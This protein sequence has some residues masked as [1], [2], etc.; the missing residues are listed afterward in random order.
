MQSHAGDASYREAALSRRASEQADCG[1]P[2]LSARSETSIAIEACRV[3]RA[4]SAAGAET[5]GVAR[6]DA[7]RLPPPLEIA[8][9]LEG[10]F[11]AIAAARPAPSTSSSTSS[12]AS[13]DSTAAAALPKPIG[14][15]WLLERAAQHISLT[16][17]LGSETPLSVAQRIRSALQGDEVAVQ[18]SLFELLGAESFE[19]MSLLMQNVVKLKSVTSSQL[20]RAVANEQRAAAKAEAKQRQRQGENS[21]GLGGHRVERGRS[22]KVRPE[23]AQLDAAVG[24]MGMYGLTADMDV[25]IRRGLPPG[26]TI[27]HGDRWEEVKV[28]PKRRPEGEVIHRVAIADLEE[29]AQLA[30]PGT[31]HLNRLQSAIF[32]QAHHS[33]ENLLVCAPTGAGKTNVAMLTVLNLVRRFIVDGVLQRDKFK[34]VYV[35]PMKALAQEVVAKFGKRLAPLGMKVNELTG[36]MQ[37][38][39]KQLEQT[40]M[41]VTTPEKW[42]VITRKSESTVGKLV[43]L[44]IFDEIHL[45][46]DGRGPVIEVLVARTL[47]RVEASQSMV[48]I[49]GLSA[50]LP[51]YKDVGEFL[52][53]NP[54]TG[55]FYADDS[56]R[57]VPLS[58]SFI[59]VQEKHHWKQQ[60]LFDEIAF[61][62][63]LRSVRQGN[64]CMIFVH[65]RN[66]TVKTAKAM[67]EAATAEGLQELFLPQAGDRA[68]QQLLSKAMKAGGVLSE[69]LPAGFGCHHAGML[70][71]DRG[72][73][74]KLFAAGALKCIVCTATLAWGVNLPAHTVIIKGTTVYNAD[75]G[76]FVQISMLDVMQIFGRA[77]RPQFDTEGEAIMITAQEHATKFVRLLTRQMPIES[78]FASALEDH[79]NAEVVAGTVASVDEA[80][81]W[82]TYTYLYTRMRRNPMCYGISWDTIRADPMLVVARRELIESAARKL[83]DCRMLR[84][85]ARSGLLA[86]TDLGR[87]ASHYYVCHETIAVW[88]KMLRAHLSDSEL[89]HVVC[90]AQEFEQLK[91]RDEE[92]AELMIL[93]RDYCPVT[94]FR[95]AA[96]SQGRYGTEDGMTAEEIRSIGAG[97]GGAIALGTRVRG[98]GKAQGR[99]HGDGGVGALASGLKGMSGSA[100]QVIA[101]LDKASA[102]DALSKANVMLQSYISGARPST[103]T[104]I[105]DSYYVG[106]N[107]ARISRALFEILMY[108][109]WGSTALA[110][111][112]LCKAIDHQLWWATSDAVSRHGGRKGKSRV[113][114]HPLRQFSQLRN[115][116]SVLEN[117]EQKRVTI[118]RLR[119]MDAHEVGALVHHVRAGNTVL[120]AANNFP[121]L[122]LSATLHPITRGILRMKVSV[123]PDFIW[124]K[125]VHGDRLSYWVW[126]EDSDSERIYHSERLNIRRG[127]DDGGAQD[128]EFVIPVEE[129]LPSQFHIYAANDRWVSATTIATVSLRHLMLPKAGTALTPLLDL[130][131]LAVASVLPPAF[132]PLFAVKFSHFNPIQTQMFHTAYHSDQSMLLGAPTGS[133]KTA[134]AELAILRLLKE[135]RG[136]KVCVYVAPLKALVRERIKDWRKRLGAL[137]MRDILPSKRG[138]PQRIRVVEVTGDTSDSMRD[139]HVIVTTPEKWDGISRAWRRRGIVKRV[140]LVIVDEI[141]LLGSDRGPVLEVLVSRMRYIS[142]QLKQHVRVVGLSTALANAGD[143]ADWLGIKRGPHGGLYNFS[144]SVRPVPID[145]HIAGYPG[146]HYC[147]RM[148]TMNRPAYASIQ[149]YA[150][151]KPTLIFVASRRQTRLTA[152][153]LISLSA[154]S[155]MPRQWVGASA[156]GEELSTIASTLRDGA[157]RDT[158]PFGVGIHHAGLSAHDRNTIEELFRNG[159]LLVLVCTSTLAWGVNFPARLVIIKGTEYFDA[160]TH[161]Y[162][163]FPITDVL[164]MMGRAGRPGHDTKGIACVLVHQP[165]KKFYQRFLYAPFPVESSLQPVLSDHMNAEIASGSV[166]TISD[167]VDYLTWTYFF[168]R[169]LQ[170]PSF[171]GLE[172]ASS[173]TVHEYLTQLV[174]TTCSE[175]QRSACLVMNEDVDGNMVGGHTFIFVFLLPCSHI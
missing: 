92:A 50:T 70:R 17:A 6:E 12:S 110:C 80:I 94:I 15:E 57:P 60:K 123:E 115:T 105:S 49:V 139:A 28:P 77:G 160:K 11:E 121:V 20:K 67:I 153:E 85:D 97:G 172:D 117:L 22:K 111:L 10:F 19:F 63:L 35:A 36:D 32:R 100:A 2:G 9:R 168:R 161:R 95:P 68:S 126:V 137:D 66:S 93:E 21:A 53:C 76:G 132:A 45:L 171:Y 25:Q 174:T 152:L 14:P 146:Q 54:E 163:D 81:E 96:K 154:A 30:F 134:A 58:M 73:V 64:Q 145:V 61:E 65:S 3:R 8:A 24:F 43:K 71:R 5:S 86:C 166:K 34:I 131:P 29:W 38:T 62:K 107:G 164:Q 147:P 167:G 90:C 89:L 140:G 75:A 79:L 23:D 51:N 99:R 84:Y 13:L 78:A 1:A 31:T 144:P 42:D 39:R 46:A 124:K 141:H 128:L 170:N 150:E 103:P 59:G 113:R 108:R 55:V 88:N 82:M 149:Q 159:K 116:P 151:G 122:R 74:E 130:R 120:A 7:A 16:P 114:W 148:A 83:D 104:L 52:R 119:D 101:A 4:A 109:G 87:V 72:L 102:V 133:G 157:L 143:L 18:M 125:G 169:L 136:R 127:D 27:E 138:R 37:L 173:S 40:Q 26:S 165:K 118:A 175:L 91:L 142:E 155:D 135:H 162:V 33:S 41:I 48:R 156:S 47:R 98:G 56:F 158:V 106:K 129:P 69:I 112:E 44:L